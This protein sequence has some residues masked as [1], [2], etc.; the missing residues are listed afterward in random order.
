MRFVSPLS[1]C[2]LGDKSSPPVGVTVLRQLS[3]NGLLL[4]GVGKRKTGGWCQSAGGVFPPAPV[5]RTAKVR[6]RDGISSADIS[7]DITIS[8]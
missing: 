6:P 7:A 8:K 4:S 5:F 1:A 2:G 3:G